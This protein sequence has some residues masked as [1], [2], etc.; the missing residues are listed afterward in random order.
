MATDNVTLIPGSSP[1]QAVMSGDPSRGGAL[2]LRFQDGDSLVLG[3]GAGFPSDTAFS[4][5]TFYPTSNEAPSSNNATVAIGSS[6]SRTI[7]G[8]RTGQSTTVRLFDL[9]WQI[10]TVT[11]TDSDNQT[12]STAPDSTWFSVTLSSASPARR[13]CSIRSW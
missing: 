12:S 5:I 2:A 7:N 9:T 4:S 1:N 13:G 3:V 10:N 8:Y 6:G 11:I